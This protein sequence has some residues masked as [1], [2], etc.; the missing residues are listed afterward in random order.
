MSPQI[1]LLHFR[2][3]EA[4]Y[5]NMFRVYTAVVNRTLQ[6]RSLDN[7]PGSLVSLPIVGEL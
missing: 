4:V 6:L 1:D 3:F 2:G 5:G 7:D